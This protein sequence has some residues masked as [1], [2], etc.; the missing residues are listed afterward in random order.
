[1]SR[2]FDEIERAEREAA[3]SRLRAQQELRQARERAG[4]TL[5]IARRLR[6][7]REANGFGALLDE[8]FGGGHG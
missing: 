4:R 1:M 2:D 7:L 6:E 8:A 5:S 3:E